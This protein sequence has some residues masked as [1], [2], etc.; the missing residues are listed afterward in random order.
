MKRLLKYLLGATAVLILA[1]VAVLYAVPEWLKQREIRA[2]EADLALLAAPP[3]PPPSAKNGIDALWLLQYRTKDDAERADLMRRFGE[4]LKYNP[5]TF[6]RHNELADRYLPPPDDNLLTFTG[7][8]AEYLPQIR[9]NLPKYRAEAEKH[10]ELFANVD[11]LADYDIFAPRNWPN[12]QEDFTKM[13][14]PRFE[15]L[16]RSHGLAA[17]DWAQ[18]GEDQAWHRVCRNIKTGRSL[19]HGRPGLIFPMIGNAV[20]RRNTGLAAQMLHEKPEWT[21]RLPA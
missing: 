6:A 8:A 4:V 12:D 21:N 13:V 9:A 11:K 7:T 3:A 18:G 17:L 5:D 10:A 20:I 19:L 14:F 1:A 15:W 2:A 16:L